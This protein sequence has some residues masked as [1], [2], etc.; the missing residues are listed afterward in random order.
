VK[1]PAY[2]TAVLAVLTSTSYAQKP[3]AHP[4]L[5]GRWQLAGSTGPAGGG[6]LVITQDATSVT[7][8]LSPAS[9]GSPSLM[10]YL[11]PG[12]TRRDNTG[13]PPVTPSS[14]T[15]MTARLLQTVSHAGWMA[16]RLV[17]VSHVTNRV[18]WP[19]E[20][21]ND[22]DHEVVSRDTYA[23]DQDGQLIVERTT[24]MDPLPFNVAIRPDFFPADSTRTYRKLR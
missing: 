13:A 9:N 3:P 15:A 5:S 1:A 16:D 18:H 21:A 23:L 8:A 2:L 10:T 24:I 14:P 20:V 6:P 4:D 22:F 7:I 11:V 19:S 12:E 17:I